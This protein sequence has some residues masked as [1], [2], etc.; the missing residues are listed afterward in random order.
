M[1]AIFPGLETLEEGDLKT[2]LQSLDLI[3]DDEVGIVLAI[4][5]LRRRTCSAV[6]G[7]FSGT[8][9]DVASLA[10]GFARGEPGAL[11]VP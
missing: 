9:Q 5:A 8:D 2:T 6:A 3:T 1:E 10:L 11:A 7:L 4:S